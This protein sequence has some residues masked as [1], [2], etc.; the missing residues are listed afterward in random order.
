MDP[1]YVNDQLDIY[2]DVADQRGLYHCLQS[3]RSI[4]MDQLDPCMSFGFLIK[5]HEEFVRFSEDLAA[6]ISEDG[7]QRIF[8]LHE[9]LD[10]SVRSVISFNSS[11]LNSAVRQ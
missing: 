9:N 2:G 1:H 3:P 7:D 10:C 5:S 6:G 4:H 8:H 11:L